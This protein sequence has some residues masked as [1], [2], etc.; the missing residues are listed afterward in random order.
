MHRKNLTPYSKNLKL[1]KE[2]VFQK[3]AQFKKSETNFGKDK[4]SFRY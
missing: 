3:K 1:V 2:S 4:T